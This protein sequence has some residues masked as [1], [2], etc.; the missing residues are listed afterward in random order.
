ME[1]GISPTEQLILNVL[2]RHRRDHVHNAQSIGDLYESV[3]REV[4]LDIQR[5]A[6]VWTDHAHRLDR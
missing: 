5:V 6:Q 2:A 4:G 1:S 3:A